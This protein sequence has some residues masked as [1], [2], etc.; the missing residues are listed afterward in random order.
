[1]KQGRTVILTVC[2]LLLACS[3]E[4]DSRTRIACVGTGITYG[5]GIV[6]RELNSYPAQLQA[7]LGENFEVR[8]FGLPGATASRKGNRS[9]FDSREYREALESAPD[10]VFVEFGTFDAAS[11]S[12]NLLASFESDYAALVESFQQIQTKPRIILLIPPPVSS[13]DTTAINNAAIREVIV[14]AIRS[15][16]YS[17]GCEIIDLYR[18]LL[19][20]PAS[21]LDQILPSAIG[22]GMIAARLYE[23]A[24]MK[25]AD[26]PIPPAEAR[27]TGVRSNYYGYDC[28]DFIFLGRSAKIVSPHLTA[29]GTPWLWRARFWGHEPQ[30]EIALLER[31]FHLVYCDVAELFGNDD[32]I[33]TWNRFYAM[34][35]GIGY[36]AKTV[37]EGFSRAGIYMY[38]WAAANPE[39]VACVYADAPVLDF[40]S[41]PGGKGKGHG[42]LEEWERFK[43]NFGL[44]SEEEALAFKG[45]PL[46][47][48]EDLAHAG[49]PML[50]VCGDADV[51]VPIEEN[52]D[53]FERKVLEAGGRIT[54]IRKPGV[55]HHPHSLPNPQPIVDFILRA[56]NRKI[57]F[58]RI[59]T[60]GNEYRGTAGW[61][62]GM[63]WH[64]LFDEMNRFGEMG[65]ECDILFFGNS[66]TQGIGRTGRSLV[67]TPGDSVFSATLAKY[68]W[69]NFGISGDRTQHVLWRVLHGNWQKLS[70]QLIVL[71]IGVNNFPD[72][73]AEEIA[74]GIRAILDAIRH[75]D[76][77]VKILL[78]GPL[79]AREPG[80]SFR[81][82]FEVVQQEMDRWADGRV[83]VHS[84]IPSA[85]LDSDGSLGTGLFAADGIHLTSTGYEEFAR[86]LASEIRE[87]GLG[88]GSQ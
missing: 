8:N 65:D 42:N 60:P 83:V 48:A 12:R 25:V 84:G 53:I 30:A 74:E 13:D 15:V 66:I 18:T 10:L 38:R 56:T 59:P 86:L 70:P 47:L 76:A 5:E 33:D 67:F 27:A 50:H 80:S 41:W 85:M 26:P 58:A 68:R 37:L 82:K 23:A 81:R 16:A 6:R 45:N 32:A 11:E 40:K 46:D 31:G 1:M 88:V 14:P 44:T 36:S 71:T 75:K 52:T 78:I 63:E 24:I 22:A 69:F 72:D 43:K 77:Q 3:S 49:F 79:P 39:K 73:T 9:Y 54:V 51:T 35:T 19:D 62:E 21:F 34:L 55:G 7:I 28:L 61:S 57:N 17:R 87:K 29:E 20:R 64:S 4:A 2:S